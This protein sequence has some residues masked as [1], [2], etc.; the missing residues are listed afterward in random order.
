MLIWETP[1]VARTAVEALAARAIGAAECLRRDDGK[2]SL[3]LCEQGRAPKGVTERRATLLF[4]A[5]RPGPEAGPWIFAVTIW[6]PEDFREELCAW[7]QYEHG[8][9]LLECSTWQGFQFLEAS[10]ED[11]CRFHVLHRL[12]ERSA[13]DSI[14]RKQSRATPWFRRMAKH[15][16]FDGAF[17]RVLA[18]RVSLLWQPLETRK[19]RRAST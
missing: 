9:L 4:S 17:E 19:P 14:Q 8:P 5:G 11:G 13:L 2:G 3:I 1:A 7:Y 18:Q 15:K 6:T 16:W 10:A 12:A